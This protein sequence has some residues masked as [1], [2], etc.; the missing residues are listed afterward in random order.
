MAYENIFNAE[1]ARKLAESSDPDKV[2]KDELKAI[3]E[4]SIELNKAREVMSK[5]YSQVLKGLQMAFPELDLVDPNIKDSPNRMARA[6]LELCAGLGSS[7][8]DV[9]STSFPAENY[10]QVIILKDIDYTSLC[11]H[12]F[13]PFKGSVSIGYLPDIHPDH[14]GKVVGLSKLARIVD[15]HAQRPQLQERLSFNIMDA[16]EKELKPAGV[17]VV[18]KGKHGCLNCRG[19]KKERASMITSALSGQFKDDNKLREEFLSLIND[20]TV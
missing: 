6:L 16:I 14:G 10:N 18:I 11:S 19:A 5:G 1:I 17:M 7:N 8:S 2:L 4:R 12:H 15:V 3:E 9:F 20:G 13:I